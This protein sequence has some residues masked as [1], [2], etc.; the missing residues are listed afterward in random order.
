MK[1]R[2]SIFEYLG[3]QR[4]WIAATLFVVL[5]WLGGAMG[6]HALSPEHLLHHT[7][8]TDNTNTGGEEEC[9]LLV[10]GNSPFDCCDQSEA[11]IVHFG[12]TE[13][14]YPDDISLITSYP[15]SHPLLRAPPFLAIDC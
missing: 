4:E 3:N 7:T 9:I 2:D 5:L 12:S 1:S 15:F 13:Y 11:Q 8:S 6:M 14:Q 10:F